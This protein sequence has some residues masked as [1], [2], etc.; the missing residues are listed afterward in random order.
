MHKL[1]RKEEELMKILWKLKKGFVK[2]LVDQ[3]PDPKPHY[4]TI[5][6]LVRL[7]QEKG[8]VGYTQY[9][10]T[11]EYYPLV[12]REEYRKSFMK[13][14]ISDYFDNSYKNAVAF[15]VNEKGLKP[16]ELEEILR[17]IRKE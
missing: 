10:N 13:G 14:V 17:M 3:Y 9:G 1:T 7:L 16:E 6:S 2:D 12:S 15:F 11:Y 5:S 4:N 8:I